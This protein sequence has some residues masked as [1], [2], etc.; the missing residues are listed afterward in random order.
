MDYYSSFPAPSY[1]EC[2]NKLIS[3]LNESNTLR[4]CHYINISTVQS[5]FEY[6]T[7]IYDNLSFIMN[8]KFSYQTSVDRHQHKP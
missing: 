8:H 2:K 7:N 1:E 3:Q 5:Q 4:K 6:I